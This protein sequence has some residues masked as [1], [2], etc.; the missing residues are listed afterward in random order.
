MRIIWKFPLGDFFLAFAILNAGRN[1]ILVIDFWF[2]KRN[3]S[4]KKFFWIYKLAANYW[5]AAS[6]FCFNRLVV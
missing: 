4:V 2:L 6:R 3:L 5:E 1:P